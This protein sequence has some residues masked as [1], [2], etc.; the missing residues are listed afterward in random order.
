MLGGGQ[1]AFLTA[2]ATRRAGEMA[3]SRILG[4]FSEAMPSGEACGELFSIERGAKQMSLECEV[5]LDR[6]EA[7]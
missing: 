5:L 7:R 3:L 6:T 2:S 1:A 4:G